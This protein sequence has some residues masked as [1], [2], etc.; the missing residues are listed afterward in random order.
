MR[1]E[2]FALA[3][4]IVENE[5]SKFDGEANKI[6]PAIDAARKLLFQMS[7]LRTAVDLHNMQGYN[8]AEHLF[9][10][11]ILRQSEADFL[12]MVSRRA[13]LQPNE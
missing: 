12:A 3:W 13:Q 9:R 6:N 11:Q 10:E 5:T 4:Q 2:C 8:V 7:W 1:P